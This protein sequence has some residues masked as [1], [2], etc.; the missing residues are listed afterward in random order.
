MM[1]T[2]ASGAVHPTPHR[3]GDDDDDEAAAG[4]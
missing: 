2:A 1:R 3:C 4:Q